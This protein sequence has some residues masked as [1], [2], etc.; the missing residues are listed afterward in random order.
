VTR[1]PGLQ[2]E[3]TALAWQRTGVATLLVAG[4][5]A[6]TAVHLDRTWLVVLAHVAL[7]LAA[8]TAVPPRR[9]HPAPPHGQLVRAAVA[10]VALAAVG[11]LLALS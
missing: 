5:A 1:D 11:V 10:T 6:F 3:R 9:R 4:G 8:A 2:P 7:G